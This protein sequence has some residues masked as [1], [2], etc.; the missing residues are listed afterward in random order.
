MAV[1]AIEG[2]FRIGLSSLPGVS[3]PAP[4][5]EHGRDQDEAVQRDVVIL[6]LELVHDRGGAGRAVAL[7]AKIFG[8][9]PAA[10][11]VQPQPD[12]LGDRFGIL[13]DAPELLGLRFAQRM[14]E[15]GANGIDENDIRHVEQ[16]VGIFEQRIRRPGIVL[17]IGRDRDLLGPERAHMQPHRAGARAAVEQEGDG[18]VGV[19][20]LLHVRRS[21]RSR[22][23]VFRRRP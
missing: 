1:T 12:E 5:V 11:L 18:P 14:A 13:G 19:A 22:R 7:A 6:A 16:R 9:V 4:K 23:A 20:R 10:M 8:A 2:R 15:A 3:A 17:G 21:R